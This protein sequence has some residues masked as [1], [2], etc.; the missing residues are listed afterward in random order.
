MGSEFPWLY[1]VSLV[2]LGSFFVMNLVLGVLSGEFSKEREKAKAR[3]DFHK[4]REKRQIEEDLRGYLD[5][6]TQAE[7]AAEKVTR[8]L[9]TA[10]VY[11]GRHDKPDTPSFRWRSS[12]SVKVGLAHRRF[13]SAVPA[14]RAPGRR[15]VTLFHPSFAGNGSGERECCAIR[16]G[17]GG[18]GRRK[19]GARGAAA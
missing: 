19:R 5:W 7:D 4:L 18:T 9:E 16:V 14:S 15:C 10:H 8:V 13:P 17:R 3:G 1:F 2:I 6:I 12:G 11:A